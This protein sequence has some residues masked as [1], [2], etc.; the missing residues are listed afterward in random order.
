MNFA[1]SLVVVW[2]QFAV[3]AA[4]LLGSAAALLRRTLQPADRRTLTQVA[5]AAAV[6]ALPWLALG[7]GAAWRVELLPQ[8]AP[9]KSSSN[10]IAT[11][12][13][14]SSPDESPLRNGS[15]VTGV[16]QAVGVRDAGG[17]AD[18][19]R[20]PTSTANSSAADD[21]SFAT[22][23]GG[24]GAL[25]AQTP[26]FW[27]TERDAGRLGWSLAAIAIL[28]AHIA[29]ALWFTFRRLVG[30]VQ[31]RRL[32]RDAAPAN[33]EM[34]A[35]WDSTVG[36]RGRTVRLLVS[37]RIDS[38]LLC[39]WRKPVVLVPAALAERG[40]S[41]LASCLAHEGAHV[42]HADYLA[43]RWIDAAQ[44]VLW[45][46]P[47][48]WTLR[49]ELRI[50]QDML[51]DHEA[52]RATG[53]AIEYSALL[54]N[55]ARQ[56]QL[57]IPAE[58]LALLDQPSQLARRVKL[59]L[60]SSAEVR[61]AASRRFAVVAAALALTLTLLA[62]AVRI[63]AVSQRQAIAGE[64]TDE[65]ADEATKKAAKKSEREPE[66]KP[67]PQVA[68]ESPNDAKEK[69]VAS[70]P[71]SKPASGPASAAAKYRC[72]VVDSASKK[73]IAG[74]TVTVRRS[75]HPSIENRLLLRTTHTTDAEGYYE[76]E[77]PA[78]Q[79]DEKFLYVEL[80]VEHPEY[81]AKR[82]FGYSYA[83]I[84]KNERLG[85]RPFYELT[86]LQPGAAITG[87]LLDPNVKPLANV[88]VTG[89]SMF[90]GDFNN[91][92]WAEGRTDQDGRFR[93]VLHRDAEAVLWLIPKEFGPIEK[94]LAKR[95]G[96]LGD[97]A[98][99]VGR[100]LKG[101]VVGVDGKPV[102]G[103]PVNIYCEGQREAASLPV[104]S[105]LRRGAISDAEG[106]FELDALA[107]GDYRLSV[108]DYLADPLTENR[109]R[110]SLSHVFLPR[111]L[112]LK[113]TG[114]VEPL[115]VQAVP[116]VVVRA[117][118]RDSSGKPTSGHEFRLYGE[119][120]GQFWA[121]NGI[122]NKEGTIKL[123]VPHGLVDVKMNLITNEHSALR[124]RRSPDS[125]LKDDTQ[126]VRLG[127]LNDDVDG[128]EIIRYVAPILLVSAVDSQGTAIEGLDIVANYVKPRPQQYI[129]L[130][131][132]S[133]FGFERQAGGV[134]RS[135][136]MLPDEE[137]KLTVSAKGFA[138][139]TERVSLKEGATRQLKVTLAKT[140][141]N[142]K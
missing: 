32:V 63:D 13:G 68:K 107:P 89:F 72:R 125:E 50:S 35:I 141:T 79:I 34:R 83:M 15:F 67:A 48:Y 23:D 82:G 51:A 100:R 80:D 142:E 70:E 128:F 118:Y 18:V 130:V 115:V 90:G 46:I 31:W 25:V 113:E 21:A 57:A 8:A 104:L 127:T 106:R 30:A 122:P 52:V 16:R 43:W 91:I 56:R 94:Y 92:S 111:S 47:A 73:G 101:Q 119:M 78:E 66:Q 7:V 53:D 137:V 1:P 33:D 124:Y 120:D 39:G 29:V 65:L 108:E 11:G 60:D 5:C 93:I 123:L 112:K 22:S 102:A 139:I 20:T 59:L 95:R 6:L 117:Q 116:H 136:Q 28:A 97:I 109:T 110:F 58:S 17:A 103:V 45:M 71:N 140:P 10:E 24:S 19:K 54:V 12:V 133:D 27:R 87:R 14:S 98:A 61:S 36:A 64:P 62:G 44:L 42:A 26:G 69:S 85:E 75:I 114:A 99:P 96:D 131:N 105:S 76:L 2:L 3:A 37:N 81:P 132:G 88:K 9:P 77:I 135:S 41:A 84:R 74:A 49:R 55:L 129:S 138:P 126:L 134:Y 121:G 40:G 4:L 86:E 38:P